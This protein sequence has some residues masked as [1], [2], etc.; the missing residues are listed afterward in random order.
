MVPRTALSAF[1]VW[2]RISEARRISTLDSEPLKLSCTTRF[3]LS[4]TSASFQLGLL[5]AFYALRAP[6]I[7]GLIFRIDAR[8]DAEGK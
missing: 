5:K 7:T 6:V 8:G 2:A 3:G 4:E 1:L